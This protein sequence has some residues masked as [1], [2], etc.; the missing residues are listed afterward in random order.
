MPKPSKYHLYRLNVIATWPDGPE[1][2]TALAAA[3]AA[4]RRELEFERQALRRAA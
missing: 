2:K 4:L 3:E 1:K